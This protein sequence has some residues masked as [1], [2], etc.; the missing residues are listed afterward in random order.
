MSIFSLGLY[1]FN[2]RAIRVDYVVSIGPFSTIVL[3]LCARD[4]KL[5]ATGLSY[6]TING[7]Q[8]SLANNLKIRCHINILSSSLLKKKKKKKNLKDNGNVVLPFPLAALSRGC[9]ISRAWAFLPAFSI[10]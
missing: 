5:G 10:T 8:T 6:F 7:L 4:C 2:C 9:P 1:F 3:W